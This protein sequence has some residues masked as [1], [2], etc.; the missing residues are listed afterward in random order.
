MFGCFNVVLGLSHAMGT[1]DMGRMQ[2]GWH[3]SCVLVGYV[4]GIYH[5][6]E[7]MCCTIMD[8]FMVI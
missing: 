3:D 1:L 5:G 7:L 6:M 2:G 8:I 4:L